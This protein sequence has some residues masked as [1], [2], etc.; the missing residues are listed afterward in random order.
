MRNWFGGG[1]GWMPALAMAGEGREPRQQE[2][3]HTVFRK[4]Q[5][6]ARRS[7]RGGSAEQFRAPEQK[8]GMTRR[9]V[10]SLILL[11]LLPPL[12]ILLIWRRRI[13]QTRGRVLLTVLSALL[14]TGVIFWLTPPEVV[15]SVSPAPAK[16]VLRTPIPTD[17]SLNAL[18]NMDE[19]LAG[20]EN[21][22]V[23]NTD[24]TESGQ[25][26]AEQQAQATPEPATE[27]DVLQTTVYS[28]R[29][30]AKYYH[31]AAE[32]N[33]QVNRRSLTVET[34][35]SEGLSACKRCNPPSP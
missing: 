22:T 24:L 13:F 34:A 21:T 17:E 19:L 29:S 15:Q 9:A 23:V 11:V 1:L 6:D 5:T 14:M 31:A 4:D 20:V 35:L 33:G 26:V 2:K 28:V 16:A 7:V 3:F 30:G 18:S 32:C 8:S 27:D 12:G 25:T 10:F